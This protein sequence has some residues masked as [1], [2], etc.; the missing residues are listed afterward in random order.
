MMKRRWLLAG[1]LLFGVFLVWIAAG[2]DRHPD[3][4]S[5]APYLSGNALEP[6]WSSDGTQIAFTT[7]PGPRAMSVPARG[8]ETRRLV[9][10]FEGEMRAHCCCI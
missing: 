10:A 4:S 8:G 7:F 9:S 6:S 3:T 1:S 2:T 5:V